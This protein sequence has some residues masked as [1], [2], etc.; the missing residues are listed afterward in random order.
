MS[1]GTNESAD[2]SACALRRNPDSLVSFEGEIKLRDIPK[3]T[4]QQLRMQ[5]TLSLGAR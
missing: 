1:K 4:L 2:W 5:I 3:M